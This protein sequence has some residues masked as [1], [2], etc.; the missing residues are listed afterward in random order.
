M[1]HET[2]SRAFLVSQCVCLTR[3]CNG[4]S[5]MHEVDKGVLGQA[6]PK[7]VIG[8]RIVKIAVKRLSTIASV[9]LVFSIGLYTP[10]HADLG[11]KFNRETDEAHSVVL[12]SSP[13]DFPIVD[14]G[15]LESKAGQADGGTSGIAPAGSTISGVRC[16]AAVNSAHYSKGAKGAIFKVR[17]TCTGSGPSTVKVRVRGLLSFTP[18]ATGKLAKRAESDES[19]TVVVNGIAKT[20]YIPEE[21]KGNG[22][23]GNGYWVRTATVQIVSPAAGTVDN[24]TFTQKSNIKKP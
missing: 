9:A 7:A 21:G 19:Q 24:G 18:T 6:T 13:L 16:D 17:V 8:E 5:S 2:V 12:D 22:G 1:S 14:T 10:A 15:Y 23:V 11:G 3:P 4:V 20:F